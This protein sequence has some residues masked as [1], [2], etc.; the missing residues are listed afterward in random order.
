MFRIPPTATG[1]GD[2]FKA[3]GKGFKREE[4]EGKMG[5]EKG[6]REKGNKE[7]GSQRGKRGGR[8]VKG[9][10]RREEKRKKG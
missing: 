5:R 9:K 6:K 10:G 7:K 4:G 2:D 8:R 3:S 1:G